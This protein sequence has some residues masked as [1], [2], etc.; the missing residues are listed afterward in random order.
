MATATFTVPATVS[1]PKQF[2]SLCA[3]IGRAGTTLDALIAAGIEYCVNQAKDG[4]NFDAFKKLAES[5]PVYARKFV[6][7]AEKMARQAHKARNWR[8]DA[9]E[10][11]K[12]TAIEELAERREKTAQ[13]RKAAKT[14]TR[15][16]APNQNTAP[17]VPKVP[18]V[19]TYKLIH[20][21]GAGNG[22]DDIIELSA[23]EFEAAKKA[24][25]DMREAARKPRGKKTAPK[26]T[27]SLTEWQEK[28]Q[29]EVAAMHKRD[30]QA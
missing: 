16:T 18:Q 30:A 13:Q 22:R 15:P 27:Q 7:D 29:A 5:C 25:Q 12:A 6:H 19:E 1:T 4:Q 8:D 23:A 28:E 3:S 10:L 2:N 26:K 11:A 21:V 9:G 24:V 17:E 14:G 20:V